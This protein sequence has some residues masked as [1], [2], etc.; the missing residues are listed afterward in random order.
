MSGMPQLAELL[1]QRLV[2]TTRLTDRYQTGITNLKFLF[3]H[4]TA[5]VLDDYRLDVMDVSTQP[6][7][8]GKVG[9]RTLSRT[10]VLMVMSRCLVDEL[11]M[12][13]R[14]RVSAACPVCALLLRKEGQL[15]LL[16]QWRCQ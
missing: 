10:F 2:S 11:L 8:S 7:S 3:S 13:R 4:P 5:I 14:Q 16:L 9:S 12:G 15:T 1:L 6:G